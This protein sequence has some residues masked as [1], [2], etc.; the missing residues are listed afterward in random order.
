MFGG[1]QQAVRACLVGLQLALLVPRLP[2][3]GRHLLLDLLLLRRRHHAAVRFELLLEL[4]K[5]FVESVS[6]LP[7]T[8]ESSCLPAYWSKAKAFSARSGWETS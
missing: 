3:E 7:L 4:G 5:L 6:R 2:V 8:C 1:V